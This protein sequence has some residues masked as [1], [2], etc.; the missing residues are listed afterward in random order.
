[1]SPKSTVYRGIKMRRRRRSWQ[2]DYGTRKGKRTQRSFKNQ[3]LAKTDID[4][5]RARERIDCDLPTAK[6]SA[7]HFCGRVISHEDQKNQFFNGLPAIPRSLWV[8]ISP[9][10][11]RD[12]SI[13]ADPHG[14]V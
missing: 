7:T 3:A 11:G 13:R 6:Y 10:P 12:P 5:H 2:V 8:W 1:M 4:A 14:S 9:H